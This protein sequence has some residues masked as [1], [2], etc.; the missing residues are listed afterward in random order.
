MAKKNVEELLIAGGK[1]EAIRKKYDVIKT[2]S[3]FV[4]VATADGYE[5][6]VEELEDVLRESGDSFESF[7]NPPKKMIWWF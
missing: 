2:T 7:G 4:E 6:S 3:E 1:S 5:F